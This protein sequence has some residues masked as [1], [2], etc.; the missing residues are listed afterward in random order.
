[1]SPKERRSQSLAAE[2]LLEE[3]RTGPDLRP[4]RY[5]HDLQCLLQRRDQG[6]H[7]LHLSPAAGRT[8]DLPS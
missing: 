7:I 5:E 4:L 1:M 6:S 2:M 3:R 8:L